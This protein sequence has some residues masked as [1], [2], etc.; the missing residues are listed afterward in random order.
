[1]TTVLM[2]A[3]SL[4]WSWLPPLAIQGGLLILL[5]TAIDFSLPR[6]TWP[7]LR[8]ALWS[9]ALVKLCLP[10]S[11]T[12]PVSLLQWSPE[13]LAGLGSA[14]GL[15]KWAEMQSPVF[16]TTWAKIL[17]LTWFGGVFVF[18][19]VGLVR[20]RQE[21]KRWRRS[22]IPPNSEWLSIAIQEA[23][24]RLAM[25]RL[26]AV[27]LQP[28]SSTPFVLGALKPEVHLPADLA[29]E[30][31]HH[32][33]LHELSHVARRDVWWAAA[34]ATLQVL[35][36]FHPLVWWARG[37]FAVVNEQCCDRSVAKVLGPDSPAYR[38]T[39]LRFAARRFALPKSSIG[40]V[41]PRSALLLRLALLEHPFAE[42][43]WLKRF[44]TSLVTTAL[45]V[46]CIPMASQAESAVG[47]IAEAIDR[48]PGCLQ[49]R[50]LVLQKL[51]QE[52]GFLQ[53][54]QDDSIVSP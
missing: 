43:V 51:A 44:V 34:A 40:F 38:K 5:V 10:P 28:A 3:T 13:P 11:L 35:Y 2:K 32:V 20:Y 25:K 12:S 42:K 9:L 18:A 53:P 22:A 29:P 6:R 39:L 50:Y 21:R 7:Q 30:E 1:M 4:W 37:R 33:L 36:W 49:I 8:A 17:F 52:E 31:A 41:R 46:A 16:L 48:P 27:F 19:I 54:D 23:G 45:L 24:D 47:T 14:S 15:T 26:P